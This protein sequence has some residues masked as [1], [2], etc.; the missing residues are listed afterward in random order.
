LA[1]LKTE[2]GDKAGA[3]SI[4]KIVVQRS[5]ARTAY[6]WYNLGFLQEEVGELEDA[7][8]SFRKALNLNRKDGFSVVWIRAYPNSA[9]SF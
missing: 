3:I 9:A 4:Y 8:F 2:A 7:E 1:Y 6:T 5:D